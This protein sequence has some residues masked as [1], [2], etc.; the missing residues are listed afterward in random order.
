MIQPK[1]TVTVLPL[2]P[3]SPSLGPDPL[4]FGSASMT[5]DRGQTLENQLQPLQEAAERLGWTVVA[6][7]YRDEASVAPGAR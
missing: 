6:I 2:N 1:R 5:S 7:Y 3:S 4:A